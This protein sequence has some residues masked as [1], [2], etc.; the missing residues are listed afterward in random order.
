MVLIFRHYFIENGASGMIEGTLEN[1]LFAYL[2]DF[3]NDIKQFCIENY[4]NDQ[5]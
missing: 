4:F 2:L 1:I 3:I 5:K